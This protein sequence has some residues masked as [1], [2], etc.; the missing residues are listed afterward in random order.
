M[1]TQIA[2]RL[3]EDLLEYIDEE[4]ASGASAS[5]AAVVTRALIRDRRRTIAERDARIYAT[6][7]GGDEDGLDNLAAWAAQQPLDID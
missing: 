2:V 4:V 6:P 7:A 1:T 5:R 3:P